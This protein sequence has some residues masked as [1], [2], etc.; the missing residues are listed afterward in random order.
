ML[1]F[2]ASLVFS[3]V[4]VEPA[5]VKSVLTRWKPQ[6]VD[7]HSLPLAGNDQYTAARI[8]TE[9]HD[10]TFGLWHDDGPLFLCRNEGANATAVLCAC[11]TA[12]EKINAFSKRQRYA[13]MHQWY[14]KRGRRA[15][16]SKKL[17]W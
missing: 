13:E 16:H 15:L 8:L 12:N 2:A 6:M 7:E 5:L 4:F 17:S 9:T 10:D 3:H 14:S 1:L 11:W